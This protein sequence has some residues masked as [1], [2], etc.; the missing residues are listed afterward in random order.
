MRR[1]DACSSSVGQSRFISPTVKADALILG[2]LSTTCLVI[3][4]VSPPMFTLLTVTYRT[5]VQPSIAI[6]HKSSQVC[7]KSATLYA[8]NSCLLGPHCLN[9]TLAGGVCGVY[10]RTPAAITSDCGCTCLSTIP[11]VTVEPHSSACYC[12]PPCLQ[13]I[14]VQRS[15]ATV[16]PCKSEVATQHACRTL[17]PRRYS[18]L[19]ASIL[20]FSLERT[21]A[22]PGIQSVGTRA[23]PSGARRRGRFE[24][25]CKT[26][27]PSCSVVDMTRLRS[28][29]Q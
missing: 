26:A 12:L 22:S 21:C 3:P 9:W 8:D 6:I 28:L 13:R 18:R 29:A 15:A 10:G 20:G 7:I 11:V 1:V 5:H 14:F 27:T 2:W 25:V 23:R 19:R 16:W 17:K 24:A 4:G